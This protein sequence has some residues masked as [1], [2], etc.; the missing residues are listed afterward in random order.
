MALEDDILRG[1]TPDD[2]ERDR[3][4]AARASLETAATQ[5]LHDLG[6][7][8]VA[9]VQGSIAKDTWISGDTDLDCFLVL[10][11][12]TPDDAL[13]RITTEVAGMVLE[14]A[15]KKYAQHP[16]LIGERDGFQVDLVPAYR[17]ESPDQRL[18]AVD[19]TPLHTAWVQSHLDDAALAQV[20]LAKQWCK[21][22]GAY[23]AETRI[24]GFSGYL[25][26]VLVHRFGGFHG[27]LEWAAA[28]CTPRRIAMRGDMVDDDVSP[29]IVVDPVDPTRNCAAAVTTDI[30]AL[31][32]EAAKSYQTAPD[33]A[34]FHP[35][36]PR[37]E[38]AEALHAALRASS[39]TWVGII[40]A[41]K[42][43]RLDIVFPQFQRAARVAAEA[44]ERAGFPVHR[45]RVDAFDDDRMV[46]MQ[47]L[48]EDATLP[49]E[50]VHEG[51]DAGKEPNAGRFREKWDGHPDAVGPVVTG[52]NG[53]LEVTVRITE[54]T[55]AA[56]LQAN[57]ATV[58]V[59]KHVTDALDDPPRIITDPAAVPTAWSA[60]VADHVLDRRP[61]QRP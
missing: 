41:P 46:G 25:L 60:A 19:R 15:R 48:L 61:W 58:L 8:G 12:D 50:R 57:L 43:D 32:Q 7:S 31:V 6:I 9:Q 14:G 21:G 26:E 3:V 33:A 1:L 35:A 59:G 22:V 27:L 37:G 30:I 24:G 51:P 28:D 4:I 29:L 18:S 11:R 2:A 47:W 17:I 5:A 38:P 45:V 13:E 36:P 49:A 40:L 23:G 10:S 16:Y 42:T 39:A 52:A 20:R 44:L 54:R 53:R 55:P 34:F 56:W